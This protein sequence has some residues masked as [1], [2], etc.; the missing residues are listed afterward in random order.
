MESQIGLTLAADS[1]YGGVGGIPPIP[2][3]WQGGGV[4]THN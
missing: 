3:V 1:L 4:G 2:V